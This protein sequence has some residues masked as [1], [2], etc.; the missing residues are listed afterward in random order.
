MDL[1]DAAIVRLTGKGATNEMLEIV[2]SKGGNLDNTFGVIKRTDDINVAWLDD[3]G[4]NYISSPT[5][6]HNIDLQTVF[7]LPD[8]DNSVKNLIIEASKNGQKVANDA[9]ALVCTKYSPYYKANYNVRVILRDLANSP[10]KNAYPEPI[11]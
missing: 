11:I 5:K 6:K 2:V 10:V 4:W 9:Y 8:A 1:G 7:S 3:Y